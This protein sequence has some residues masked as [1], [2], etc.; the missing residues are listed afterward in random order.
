MRQKQE[1]IKLELNRILIRQKELE[2]NNERL[3][4]HESEI[5]KD[6]RHIDT[7]NWTDEEYEFMTRRDEDLL[8]I[9]EFAAVYNTKHY[10]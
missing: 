3:M 1:Q 2:E 9:K 7:V 10:N 6:I 5:K 8:T 4:K